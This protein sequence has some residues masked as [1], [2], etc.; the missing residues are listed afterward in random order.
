MLARTHS[1][2]PLNFV[3][4]DV[5]LAT[6]SRSCV[7]RWVYW[8]AHEFSFKLCPFIRAFFWTF[9]QNHQSIYRLR[10]LWYHLVVL[11]IVRITAILYADRFPLW[12][13]PVAREHFVWCRLDPFGSTLPWLLGLIMTEICAF[14]Q[15]IAFNIFSYMSG[16]KTTAFPQ[17]GR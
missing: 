1:E 11:G 10:S 7:L 13:I 8:F 2:N 17:L 12:L 6:V 14:S 9:E 15:V 3:A 4:V 16:W 5:G